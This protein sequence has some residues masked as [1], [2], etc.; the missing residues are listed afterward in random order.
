MDINWLNYQGLQVRYAIRPGKKDSIPLLMFNGIG[1]SLEVFEPL[2]EELHDISIVT[3]DIPGAGLSDSPVLP[4][5]FRQY[6]KLA[7]KLLDHLNYERVHVF[8]VSWGGGLAQQFAHQFPERLENLILA[9]APPGHLMVPG[10]PFAYLR[11]FNLRRFWD[12]T[13]MRRIAPIIYGGDLRDSTVAAE[14]LVDRQHSPSAIGYVYQVLAMC[15]W[16]SLPFLSTLRQPTLIL[17]GRD[18]PLLPNMNARLLARLIPNNR[19]EFI[20]CGHLFIVTRPQATAQK[21][22]EFA[23]A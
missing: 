21:I 20:D 1:Q 3:L 8:G 9:A 2:I 17:Q 22:R 15:G 11:M 14:K 23:Y 6:A 4:W 7:A 16:S 5:R 13:Y 19:L 12:K 10:N 18:D